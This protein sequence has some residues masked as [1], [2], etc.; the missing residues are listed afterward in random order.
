MRWVKDPELVEEMIGFVYPRKTN[1]V[2]HLLHD[3]GYSNQQQGRLAES[4]Y[5]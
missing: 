2:L 1:H 4:K 5:S 3:N